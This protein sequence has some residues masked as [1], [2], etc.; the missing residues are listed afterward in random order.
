MN[1]TQSRITN[2]RVIACK[3]LTELQSEHVMFRDIKGAC[4]EIFIPKITNYIVC[5]KLEKTM[6]TILI[7]QEIV[8]QLCMLINVNICNFSFPHVH[9]PFSND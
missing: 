8:E 7:E 5:K 6:F 9:C 4:S 3:L 1:L 2:D